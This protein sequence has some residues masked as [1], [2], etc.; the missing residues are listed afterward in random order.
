LIVMMPTGHLLSQSPANDRVSAAKTLFAFPVL[1][2]T[3]GAPSS[4]AHECSPVRVAR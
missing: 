1:A 4:T 3:G 2:Q